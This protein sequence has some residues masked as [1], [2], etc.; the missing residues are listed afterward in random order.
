MGE[1]AE[2]RHWQWYVNNLT[3][4]RFP[5]VSEYMAETIALKT[6]ESS[7]LEMPDRSMTVVSMADK[8]LYWYLK[9]EVTQGDSPVEVFI[10]INDPDRVFPDCIPVGGFR[11]HVTH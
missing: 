3:L 6:F 9:S 7:G 8:H 1:Y 11:R 10:D 2:T 5:P 4:D